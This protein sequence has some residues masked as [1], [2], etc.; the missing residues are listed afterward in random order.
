MCY[1][2]LVF[3]TKAW[4]AKWINI[5]FGI[6]RQQI[7]ITLFFAVRPDSFQTSSQD[8]VERRLEVDFVV[9]N[10]EEQQQVAD[11]VGVDPF[12]IERFEKVT[13]S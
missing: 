8:Y 3:K 12:D 5:S 2:N 6:D 13:K 1:N 9:E 10:H 4:Q 7:K 11:Y